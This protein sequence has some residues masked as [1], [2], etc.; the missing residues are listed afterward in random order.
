MTSFEILVIVLSTVFAVL[1]LLTVVWM[2]I[3][4]KIALKVKRIASAA[5]ELVEDIEGATKVFKQMAAPSAIAKFAIE[6]ITN[7]MKSKNESKKNKE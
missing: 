4:I 6:Q 1:L 7:F 2:I 5:E 3:L